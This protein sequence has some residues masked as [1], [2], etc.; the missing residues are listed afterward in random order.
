MMVKTMAVVVLAATAVLTGCVSDIGPKPS[1]TTADVSAV[2]EKESEKEII[3]EN[4]MLA[5]F[6]VEEIGVLP[7]GTVFVGEDAVVTLQA[8]REMANSASLSRQRQY[9]TGNLVGRAVEVI[10]IKPSSEFAANGVLSKALDAAI[11]SF[12][13]QDL[14]FTMQVG[15]AGCS[16]DIKAKVTSGNG[17][18]AGFPANGLPY[19][20][21]RIGEMLG[22]GPDRLAKHLIMHELGHC[23]GFRHSDYYDRSI[24]CGGSSPKPEKKQKNPYAANHIPGTPA[25]AV[26]NGSVMNACYNSGSD[27]EWTDS[28]IEA[29][30]ALYAR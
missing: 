21:F 13:S 14:R 22:S 1:E 17:G 19:D 26:L 10:C 16:A 12:N 15:N 7:D 9:S 25:T 11:E 27:G 23:V 4:L 24:S 28:D 20:Q 5:D 18:K 3:I 8:S 6:P 29:L 2:G 30:Q